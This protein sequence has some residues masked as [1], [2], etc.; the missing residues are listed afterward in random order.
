MKSGSWAGD[1][2][3]VF[4]PL[5][6]CCVPVHRSGLKQCT[7]VACPR[8]V[9]KTADPMVMMFLVEQVLLFV[10]GRNCSSPSYPI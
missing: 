5:S 7:H 2:L 3:D 6:T 8:D 4:V 9:C 1:T 10:R